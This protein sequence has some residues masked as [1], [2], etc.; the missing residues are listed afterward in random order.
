M[1]FVKVGGIN[2]TERCNLSCIMCHFHG[3]NAPKKKKTLLVETVIKFMSQVQPQELW[4]GGTGDVLKDPHLLEHLQYACNFGHQPSIL[5]NGQLL[6][7]TLMDKMLKIGVRHFHLSV[8][9]IEKEHYEYVRRGGKFEKILE[10]CAYLRS[11]KS[12]YPNLRVEINV[13]LLEDTFNRQDEFIHFWMG[14]VDAISFANEYEHLKFK[15]L[16]FKPK[17]QYD[18]VLDIRLLPTGHMAPCC[19]IQVYQHYHPLDWLPHI[20]VITP[21]EA[22]QQFQVMYL[23]STSPFRQIC[24]ECEWWVISQCDEY[25]KSPF[26]RHISLNEFLLQQV[27]ITPQQVIQQALQH[28]QSGHLVQAETLYRQVLQ[29]QPDNSEALH[30][31]GVIAAQMENYD[32]AIELMKQAIAI[33]HGVPLFYSNLAGVFLRQNNLTEACVHYQ[34]ALTLDPH[35]LEIQQRLEKVRSQS[36]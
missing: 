17:R 21:N 24:K 12:I 1:H 27:I 11:Q 30:F 14:K 26:S 36:P 7:P 5:T 4:F 32:T 20:D 25:G 23:D 34:H 15:R 16:F 8:D 2:L 9:S 22:Y 29:V 13:T 31:L 28:H 33:N 6:T 19:A 3:P 10:V 35:N 18:C